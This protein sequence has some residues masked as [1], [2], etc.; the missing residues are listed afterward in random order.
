MKKFPNVNVQKEK[1][2]AI[3]GIE[4][5]PNSEEGECKSGERSSKPHELKKN[6]LD[7]EQSQSKKYH[8]NI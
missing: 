3:I 1:V 2:R 5:K 7:S 8:R 6:R 4:H